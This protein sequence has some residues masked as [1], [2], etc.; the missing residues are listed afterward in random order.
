MEIK[1]E[2]G[3][4]PAGVNKTLIKQSEKKYHAGYP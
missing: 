3:L 1:R 2:T 4:P